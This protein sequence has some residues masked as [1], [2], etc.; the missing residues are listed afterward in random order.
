MLLSAS[1]K[2]PKVENLISLSMRELRKKNSK[3]C[4]GLREK[5]YYAKYF[6]EKKND[7]DKSYRKISF[8]NLTRG[9]CSS[10]PGFARFYL[11]N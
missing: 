1:K 2:Q 11:A 3:I 8:L 10:D 4:W 7:G 6:L 9:Y 5:F